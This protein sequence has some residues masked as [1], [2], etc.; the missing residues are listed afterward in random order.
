MSRSRSPRSRYP[1]PARPSIR[2]TLEAGEA[3]TLDHLRA[4]GIQ[5]DT[6]LARTGI[7]PR[8][9]EEYLGGKRPAGWVM[10]T[11][12]GALRVEPHEIWPP[13]DGDSRLHRGSPD[14]DRARRASVNNVRGGRSRGT[15]TE[16]MTHD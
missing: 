3:I 11:I 8:N 1:R 15:R 6:L 12:A 5:I 7:A 9:L 10:R 13:R 4:N 16:G 14:D 2:A